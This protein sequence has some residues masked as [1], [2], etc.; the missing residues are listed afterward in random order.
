MSLSSYVMR[1]ELRAESL[2][3]YD[4]AY[5]VIGDRR[6]MVLGDVGQLQ[7]CRVIGFTTK[8]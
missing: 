5:E 3:G 8:W 7:R 1:F 6:P 4:G 2:G